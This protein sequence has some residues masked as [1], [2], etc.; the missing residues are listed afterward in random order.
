MRHQ[1]V[2]QVAKGH[3]RAPV[4][5]WPGGCRGH[6]TTRRLKRWLTKE[7][8]IEMSQAEETLGRLASCLC[9]GE[10]VD[11]EGLG[12]EL[13]ARLIPLLASPLAGP[14]ATLQEAFEAA[15]SGHEALAT[16]VGDAPRL[17]WSF[18]EEGL[19]VSV[20]ALLGWPYG[21]VL[22]DALCFECAL[23]ASVGVGE[24]CLAANTAALV[25][26][27]FDEAMDPVLSVIRTA[28]AD[29]EGEDTCACEGD[30][31]D[32]TCEH[33]HGHKCGCDCDDEAC[34]CEDDC[35]CGHDHACD[36]GD[37]GCACDHDHDCDDECAKGHAH[38][39]ACGCDDEGVSGHDHECACG[40]GDD[41]C[42]CEHDHD[43]DCGDDA[44][45]CGHDDDDCCDGALAVG[46]AIEC[47]Q[48]TPQ[49]LCQAV[50]AISS[51]YPDYLVACTGAERCATPEDV[52]LV[53]ATVEP[54]V[55]VRATT[56]A[57]TV[58][59]AVELFEAGA[60]ELMCL[61]ASQIL[62]DFD[63]LATSL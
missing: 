59:E 26:G 35:D 60:V 13:A 37:E 29:D 4:L 17:A 21:R 25:E 15:G 20:T 30:Y 63:R 28:R 51:A 42:A 40:C 36:C 23:L 8:G 19:P 33:G 24:V 55:A 53:C 61:H 31:D 39:C 38:E 9:E 45:G 54:G 47:G 10:E 52:R 32:C 46:V 3:G 56:D 27:E 18:G 41:G 2:L 44:C 50:D 57:R 16:W 6:L 58:A 1:G 22:G 48:L 12:Q 49:T 62:L 34:T 7:K 11:L 14:G 5:Y 43:C